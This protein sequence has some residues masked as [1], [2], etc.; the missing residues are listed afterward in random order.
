ARRRPQIRGVSGERDGHVR[1]TD[2]ERKKGRA[3][4]N[5][6]RGNG[7]GR[8]VVITGG[9]SGVGRATAVRFATD[10]CRVGLLARGPDGL[11][12]A[13][14]DVEAHGGVAHPVQ[15]DVAD[16]EQVEAAAEAV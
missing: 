3:S 15:T 7:N 5:I 2:T 13:A 1:L 4:M 16:P 9:T 11:E 8:V 10:G 12:A 6:Q 14:K